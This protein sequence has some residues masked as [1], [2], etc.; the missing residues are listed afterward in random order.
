M[1]APVTLPLKCLLEVVAFNTFRS[2]FVRRTCEKTEIE[3]LGTFCVWTF[4]DSVCA[5][6][7]R[8]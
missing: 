7:P 8:L 3:F 6:L 5:D 4:A 2:P 1:D